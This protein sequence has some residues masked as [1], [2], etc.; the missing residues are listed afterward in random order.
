[1]INMFSMQQKR[2]LLKGEFVRCEA[3]S[4]TTLGGENYL[5][6]GVFPKAPRLIWQAGD[7][8]HPPV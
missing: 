7:K 4:G 2:G 8:E 6:D 1:M 3:R 5:R